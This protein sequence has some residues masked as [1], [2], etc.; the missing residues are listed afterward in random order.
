[1]LVELLFS[2][3][4]ASMHLAEVSSQTTAHPKSG[5]FNELSANH[6]MICWPWGRTQG[7]KSNPTCVEVEIEVQ[8]L[9]YVSS[10]FFLHE[11]SSPTTGD[12]HTSKFNFWAFCKLLC[13][14]AFPTTEVFI[15]I[16][17]QASLQNR[18]LS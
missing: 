6:I 2:D 4:G 9:A 18:S 13:V 3:N 5:V 8:P 11:D 15:L 14:K 1:M 12:A 10:G 7:D 16:L 17:I